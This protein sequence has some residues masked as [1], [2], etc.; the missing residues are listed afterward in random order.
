MQF[1]D[2]DWVMI[3]YVIYSLQFDILLDVLRHSFQKTY[4]LVLCKNRFLCSIRPT[5]NSL[6][7]WC[8]PIQFLCWYALSFSIYCMSTP[9]LIVW[10]YADVTYFHLIFLFYA[11]YFIFLCKYNNKFWMLQ[12]NSGSSVLYKYV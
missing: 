6:I 9:I 1:Y 3:H 11:S 5:E 10:W 12:L 2:Q 8:R 7:C 4:S